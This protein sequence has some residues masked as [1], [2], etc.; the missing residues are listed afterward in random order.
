MPNNCLTIGVN[1]CWVGVPIVSNDANA[2]S[3]D[4]RLRQSAAEYMR[5]PS[6]VSWPGD[7]VRL[8]K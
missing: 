3:I 8:S 2:V 7:V 6:V 1:D 4:P 5:V